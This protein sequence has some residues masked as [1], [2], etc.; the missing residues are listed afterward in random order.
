MKASDW[1]VDF[2]ISKGV[3]DV[4]GLP[5]AVVLEL[6]YAM[7][8]RKPELT[9][10]LNYH[11]QGAA[12]AACGYAQATG[13][14]G[15]AYATRGPGMTNMLTAIADAYYDSVPTMFFTAHSSEKKRPEMRVEN[16]QEIDTTAIAANVTKYAVRIDHAEDLQPE[17]Q[18]A[19]A[20]ATTGRKGPVFLDISSSVLRQEM[21]PGKSPAI[22]KESQ[23]EDD[24]R[25]AD[26]IAA[27]LRKA[28]RPV[29][30]IGGGVQQSDT[31]ELVRKLAKR[32]N[33]PV[34]SS[35]TTHDI[36]PNDPMYFG[37]IG[38]HGTRY[39]NFILSKADCILALGNRMAFP[40]R[41]ESFRPVVE[42]SS[43]IR[44]DIDKS[45]FLREMPGSLCYKIGLEALLPQLLKK[46]LFNSCRIHWMEICE[47]LKRFLV[48][49]D[50]TPAVVA[51]M[52]LIEAAENGSTLVCDVGNHSFL[53]T[54]ACVYSGAQNR[55]IYS[56][57]F[58]TLGSALPKAIGTYY[59]TGRSVVCFTGDQG[60]QMNLQEL[61]FIS[62]HRLPIAIVVINNFASAMIREREEKQF[63][64]FVHTTLE[65]GY[66]VPDLR[67]VANAYHLQYQCTEDTAVLSK[68]D[69]SFGNEPCLI[70]LRTDGTAL[71][72]PNLPQGKPCQDMAPALP[73]ELYQCLNELK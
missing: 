33:I 44:V 47:K 34:L 67:A 22:Q 17:L 10:H 5:G 18:K 20:I 64:H 12:F 3:T 6:L 71:L 32:S 26:E 51:L 42:K 68:Q 8:R 37:F 29:I 36:M 49:W 46:D 43:V 15:V 39:S 24:E 38:S 30:L 19:Y 53:V 55:T 23:S 69:I 48:Q 4:F 27:K 31:A 62:Q 25:I 2:L 66:G 40:V 41:S 21:G 73:E 7:D 13:K 65:S 52:R 50:K 54:N 14:M 45:E 72:R 61:Q 11:E 35:R 58:G 16:N 57:S 28:E 63:P 60:F 1:I 59:G 70:E 56:G 9:P